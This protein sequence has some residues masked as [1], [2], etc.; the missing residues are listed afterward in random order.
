MMLCVVG[1]VFLTYSTKF[2]LSQIDAN[3]IKLPFE[4]LNLSY[5]PTYCVLKGSH[6]QRPYQKEMPNNRMNV[7]KVAT[8]VFT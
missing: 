4:P 6:A 1:V 5:L 2:I 3:L 7:Q 8:T